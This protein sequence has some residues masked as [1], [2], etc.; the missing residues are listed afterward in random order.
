VNGKNGGAQP[1]FL[2]ASFALDVKRKSKENLQKKL[3]ENKSQKADLMFF[4]FQEK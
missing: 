3:H 2:H 4:V 1:L